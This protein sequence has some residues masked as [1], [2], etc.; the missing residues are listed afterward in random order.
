MRPVL[1]LSIH[2]KIVTFWHPSLLQRYRDIPMLV[3]VEKSEKEERER[4]ARAQL[5]LSASKKRAR[6]ASGS[7]LSLSLSLPSL[8]R[9]LN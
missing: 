4:E 5:L 6:R 1:W 9:S 7:S 2:R 8:L 3:E